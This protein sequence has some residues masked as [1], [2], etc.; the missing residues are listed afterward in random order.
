[1]SENTGQVYIFT[2]TGKGKTSAALG[3]TT[4]ALCQDWQV[5]W[6]AWYKEPQWQVSEFRL[7]QFFPNLTM[8]I[9]GKGF[10]FRDE[11]KPA[12][13][14][15]GKIFTV[16]VGSQNVV[17]K[18]ET[19]EHKE[20]AEKTLVE[21][22]KLLGS[23]TYQL[24]VLDEICQAVDQK[25]ISLSDVQQLINSRGQCHLVLTGRNCSKRL[26]ELADTVTE[27]KKLKHAF[28]AGLLAVAGLDY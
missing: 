12:I 5:A 17:D 19:N 16:P 26:I 11:K 27:M 7:P 25:L 8:V 13:Q 15:H 1:M 28:D 23:G 20:A 22:K 14:K 6:I 2:G 10:Y 3:M 18:V 24:L 9:G 4:R 21:A